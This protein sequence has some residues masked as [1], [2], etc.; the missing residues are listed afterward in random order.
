MSKRKKESLQQSIHTSLESG[1]NSNSNSLFS[2]EPI[3]GTPFELI[4]T[5][6]GYMM[7]WGKYKISRMTKTAEE[8]INLLTTDKWSI[9]AVYIYS[10]MDRKN[11]MDLAKKNMDAHAKANPELVMKQVEKQIKDQMKRRGN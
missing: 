1:N 11:E 7:V 3:E 4:E 2:R 10:L 8:C 9:I 6:E 5:Q